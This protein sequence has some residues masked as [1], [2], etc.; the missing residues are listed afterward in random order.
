MTTTGNTE[1]ERSMTMLKIK[2]VAERLRCQPRCG[3]PVGGHREAPRAPHHRQ[4]DTRQR[5]GLGRIP[6][7]RQEERLQHTVEAREQESEEEA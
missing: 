2:E 6:G 5:S 7:G 3:D 4:G 1:G